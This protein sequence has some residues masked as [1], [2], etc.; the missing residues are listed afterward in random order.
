MAFQRGSPV[1]QIGDVRNEI[2]STVLNLPKD[3]I[4]EHMLLKLIEQLEKYKI[5]DLTVLEK[6]AALLLEKIAALF[7]VYRSVVDV[8]AIKTFAAAQPD[9]TTEKE[10]I[11]EICEKVR[12][13]LMSITGS[14][15]IF[16]YHGT[17]RFMVRDMAYSKLP[18]PTCYLL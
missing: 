16:F 10:Q 2:L 11:I 17:Y 4:S 8:Q 1:L 15:D 7:D 6:I 14:V 13:S 18:F 3:V 5:H 12:K 9:P